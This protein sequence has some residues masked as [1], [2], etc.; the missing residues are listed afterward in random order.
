MDRIQ[1]IASLEPGDPI[2]H[3]ESV[4]IIEAFRRYAES[5]GDIPIAQC[6][7]LQPEP[8]RSAKTKRDYYLRRA[9]SVFEPKKIRINS[10]AVLQFTD[11]VK[12]FTSLYR[13]FKRTGRTPRGR[14]DAFLYLAFDSGA[15]IPKSERQLSR[16]VRNP[17]K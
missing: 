7:G 16:I 13:Q 3:T 6:F 9:F 15:R 10:N 8:F 5:G 4:W 12:A 17:A 11:E 2:P 14:M 1:R